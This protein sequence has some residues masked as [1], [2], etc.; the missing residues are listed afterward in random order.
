MLELSFAEDLSIWRSE[1]C[2]KYWCLIV[3]RNDSINCP[4]K[5]GVRNRAENIVSIFCWRLY[6]ACKSVRSRT[7]DLEFEMGNRVKW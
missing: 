7:L 3:E 2:L 5:F 4:N 1:M 6:F